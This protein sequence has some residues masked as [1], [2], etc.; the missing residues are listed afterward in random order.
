MNADPID[1][2]AGDVTI[3]HDSE[4]H[5][6]EAADPRGRV[7]GYLS[8]DPVSPHVVGAKG[9]FVAIHTMVEPDMADVAPLLARAALDHAR[10][11]HLTVIAECPYVRTFIERH[12][13]YQDLVP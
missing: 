9:M 6:F 13:E 12:P 10:A 1:P 11:E 3:Q 8:Y 5:R 4:S 7:V 2:L